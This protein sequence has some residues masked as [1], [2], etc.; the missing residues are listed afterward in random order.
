MDLADCSS[1]GFSQVKKN[2]KI[3][4]KLGKWMGGSSPNSDFN[5]F[6]EI[7]CFSVFFVLFSCSQLFPKKN[8]K[9]G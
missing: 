9:N 5:F 7:V 1:K 4:E 2:P 8:I 6:G 3:Q